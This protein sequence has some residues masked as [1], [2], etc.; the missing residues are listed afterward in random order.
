[1]DLTVTALFGTLWFGLVFVLSRIALSEIFSTR[2]R[3][4]VAA[5]I[6]LG[7]VLG[8]ALPKHWLDLRRDPLTEDHGRNAA[9]SVETRTSPRDPI[10]MIEPACRRAQLT[11]RKVGI[12]SLDEMYTGQALLDSGSATARSAKL[13]FTGWTARDR[14]TPSAATCLAVDGRIVPSAR[15]TYGHSRPDVAAAYGTTALTNT[16]FEIVLA[17][18]TLAPGTHVVE[19]VSVAANGTASIASQ[20]RTIEIRP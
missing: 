11:S 19:A 8:A 13:R 4:F 20:R 14:N 9:A 2:Q 15:G 18:R 6:A 10:A 7:L 1:V 5:A 16:G 17:P 12:G 3:D